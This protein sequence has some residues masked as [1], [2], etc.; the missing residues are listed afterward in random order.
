MYIYMPTDK[1]ARAIRNR[2]R[3][4][5]R[6]SRKDV[7]ATESTLFWCQ[8]LTLLHCYSVKGWLNF[9]VCLI[10]NRMPDR[11][12]NSHSYGF[13][14]FFVIL[15]SVQ[16][17]FQTFISNIVGEG[18]FELITDHDQSWRLL[19]YWVGYGYA[20]LPKVILLTFQ[21]R[22]DL[23]KAS[24]LNEPQVLLNWKLPKRQ[25]LAEWYLTLSYE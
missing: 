6:D 11:S 18:L 25:M 3:S 24:I 1:K 19:S 20:R 2:I 22:I 12:D 23:T 17:Q 8:G 13:W 21:M 4:Q 10:E 9:R 15:I 14:L 7:Q 16:Q 5:H